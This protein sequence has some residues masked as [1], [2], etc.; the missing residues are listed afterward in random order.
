MSFQ[1]AARPIDAEAFRA[2]FVAKVK[3]NLHR[4]L[5]ALSGGQF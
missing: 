2:R 1:G 3:E 4:K 5:I